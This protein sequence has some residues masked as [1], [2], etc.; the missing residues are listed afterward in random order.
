MPQPPMYPPEAVQPFRDELKV[1]GF[2]ELLTPEEVD[3]MRRASLEHGAI[4]GS[5][6]DYVTTP[7]AVRGALSAFRT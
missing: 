3:G 5:I 2:R 7:E 4:G 6:Y 1:V